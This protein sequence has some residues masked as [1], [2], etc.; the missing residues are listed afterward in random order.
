M[1]G[2]ISVTV[3]MKGAVYLLDGRR[4][5]VRVLDGNAHELRAFSLNGNARVA[6]FQSWDLA[7]ARDTVMIVG[8]G[9][10]NNSANRPR[11]PVPR[12]LLAY[13]T[14][15]AFLSL[16]DKHDIF[17]ST[18]LTA[19]DAG[20]VIGFGVMDRRTPEPLSAVVDTVLVARVV[21]ASF[22]LTRIH[23]YPMLPRISVGSGDFMNQRMALQPTHAVASDGA[24]HTNATGG[25][26]ID[27]RSPAGRLERRIVGGRCGRESEKD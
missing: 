19:T 14:K 2:G 5:R 4:Q 21:P 23:A 11:P 6:R 17:T 10:R 9:F 15:G 13:S 25:F 27:V 20:W 22:G 24:I 8:S 12:L 1:P 3:D 7:V 18:N 26:V 16:S